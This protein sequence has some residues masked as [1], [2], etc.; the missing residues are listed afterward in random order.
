MTTQNVAQNAPQTASDLIGRRVFVYRN[1][2][3]QCWSVR[4]QKTRR[5]IAHA[6]SVGLEGCCELKVSEKGQQRVVREGR[7]NVHAGI[8]GTVWSASLVGEAMEDRL[9]SLAS[10]GER[11]SYNPYR[12]PSF[13]SKATG[14]DLSV[15]DWA[16]L[17]PSGR[18]F[19]AGGA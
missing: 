17:T 18:V 6:D 3:S 5:V 19:I 11:I 15:A 13:Y 14:E 7:K 4:C 10:G 12:G 1:L 2:H 9:H 8:V 16:A